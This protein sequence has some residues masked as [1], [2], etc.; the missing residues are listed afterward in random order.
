MGRVG[1]GGVSE[2][3][4]EAG[5][6]GDWRLAMARSV[7]TGLR[8][9]IADVQFATLEMKFDVFVRAFE[10]RYRESQPRAP[11]GVPEGGQWIANSLNLPA[12]RPDQVHV[13]AMLGPR[14]D[15]FS[16]GCQFG[17]TFGTTGMYRIAGKNLCRDCAVKFLG[18]QGL[19]FEEQRETL[20]LYDKTNP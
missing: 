18:I 17:G 20:H 14:C 6:A 2:R 1:F 19:S 11:A 8:A 9:L 12:E 4:G 3:R 15:G 10:R 7:S 13:A 16:A 5:D